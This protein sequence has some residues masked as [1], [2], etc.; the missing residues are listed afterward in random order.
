MA[1]TTVNCNFTFSYSIHS[2][3]KT[4]YFDTV[5]Q[6]AAFLIS[7]QSELLIYA[8]RLL[9]VVSGAYIVGS[10]YLQV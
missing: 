4:K 8:C 10:V 9:A 2:T 6:Q 5:C 1:C 7:I 3:R